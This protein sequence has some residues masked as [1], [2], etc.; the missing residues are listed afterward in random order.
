[1]KVV[2]N[3]NGYDEAWP[4]TAKEK[5]LFVID[6]GVDAIKALTAEK[7]TAMFS[8]VGVLSPE[9]CRARKYILLEQYINTVQEEVGCLVSMI[10]R[11][12]MPSVKDCGLEMHIKTL[13]DAAKTLE[14]DMK[15]II[16]LEEEAE[17]MKIQDLDSSGADELPDTMMRRPF[18]KVEDN[19][20]VFTK[21]KWE[22]CADLD[23][24]AAKARETRLEHMRA[25]RLRIDEI[26]EQVPIEMWRLPSYAKLFFID[27]TM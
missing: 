10:R 8:K 12:V 26:E 9:E 20:G 23:L 27:Q 11:Q 3:G 2:F 14:T 22:V 25:L 15:E 1:M 24:A 7:N 21:P 19:P 4:K 13:E 17:A 18:N 5:G 16:N 6:S